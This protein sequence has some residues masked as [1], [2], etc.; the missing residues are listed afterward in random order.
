MDFERY[1]GLILRYQA[2][3]RRDPKGYERRVALLGLAGYAYLLAIAGVALA[4]FAGA[5]WVAITS[6]RLAPMLQ[7]TLVMGGIL[8]MIG[9]A[10]WVK[11]PSP[12]GL[13]IEREDAP[14][15]FEL[16]DEIRA[17]VGAP[18]VHDIHLTDDYN[19]GMLQSP[20]L[21]VFGWHRNVLLLGLPL[22]ESLTPVQLR[23]VIGHELGHLSRQHS[24]LS[25][26]IYRVRQTWDR[27]LEQLESR[28]SRLAFLFT[29]FFRWYSPHFSAAS[30]VLV[31]ADEFVA[32]AC[33]A[34]VAG[35]VAAR[36][37]LGRIELVNRHAGRVVWPALA[38]EVDREP[39]PVPGRFLEAA[40]SLRGA[41][42]ADTARTD[43]DEAL[44]RATD[45]HDT[46]PA[47]AERLRALAVS[48]N[49]P[50]DTGE[51]YL[52]RVCRGASPESAAQRYLG[53][54]LQALSRQV[55]ALW[56]A[57]VARQWAERHR[58]RVETG[59][60]L[61]ALEARPSESLSEDEA[62]TRVWSTVDLRGA[63]AALPALETYSAGHPGHALAAFLLGRL[64]LARNDPRGI[65]DLERA[66]RL[67]SDA[68]GTACD[69]CASFLR[70]LGRGD[71]ADAWQRRGWQHH[72]DLR[73]AHDERRR[74]ARRARFLP[75]GLEPAAT[76]ALREALRAVPGI[77]RAVL[78]RREVKHRADKPAF[79]LGIVPRR[80]WYRY[81]DTGRERKLLRHVAVCGALPEGTFVFLFA[82]SLTWARKRAERVAGAVLVSHTGRVRPRE[83]EL[84][85]DP[86]PGDS[87]AA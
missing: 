61:E 74:L 85:Q 47:F 25:I 65:D 82:D 50:D 45:Y 2:E 13:R 64:R 43:L 54:G 77:E 42:A 26:W 49:V 16:V 4:L 79:V 69:L 19:A 3:S 22:L 36:E 9:R 37:A 73:Q 8:W 7:G 44:A 41:L 23:A 35:T 67:D 15:L 72:E 20:R 6:H 76:A 86:G 80:P 62:W 83:Q 58:H 84:A 57:T 38:A 14:R 39:R 46:H 30:F 40:Q 29:G 60:R 52:A 1:R 34:R 78:V 21:G 51:E 48:Q 81:A 33:A 11:V 28:G 12:R 31:R 66:I 71:E 10:L 56:C 70:G 27:L 55:D 87:R 53:A 63:E 18:R 5:I 59:A 24:R 75:H 32:D 68:T 17:A